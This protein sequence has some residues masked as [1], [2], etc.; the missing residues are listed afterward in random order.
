MDSLPLVTLQNIVVQGNNQNNN[1]NFPK[2]AAISLRNISQKVVNNITVK[3]S[4]ATIDAIA[5]AIIES[6][7]LVENVF[8]LSNQ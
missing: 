6:S 1:V 7:P 5:I 3:S 2:S 8:M 4:S